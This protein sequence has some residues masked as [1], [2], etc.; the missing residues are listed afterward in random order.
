LPAVGD[1]PS[2]EDLVAA[3][4]RWSADERVRDAVVN[5]SY[6]RRIEEAASAAATLVGILV[7]L[8]EARQ[9]VV[10]T[11][12]R[13]RISTVIAGVG[14]DFCVLEPDGGPP[15]L[16]V[17]RAVT[18]IWPAPGRG[19]IPTGARG[20][21]LQLSFESALSTLAEDRLPVAMWTGDSKVEGDLVAI[22][23]DVA[24]LRTG[25]PSRRV[26]YVPLGAVSVCELR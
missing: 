24:T 26:A 5:R 22:G 9:R 18:S 17:I 6:Q 7:D 3:F 19:G 20:P 4:G 13:R 25:P 10:F 1:Q 2:G 14:P 8:A 15:A 11:V 16:V 21:V 12:G 23:E